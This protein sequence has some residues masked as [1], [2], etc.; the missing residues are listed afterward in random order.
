LT[1]SELS[2]F[3]LF[4]AAFVLLPGLALQRLLRTPIDPA[5][6]VPLG[7]A[8]CAFAF[9]VSLVTGLPALLPAAVVLL[10]AGAW[11]L[12]RGP[13]ERASGPSLRATPTSAS[14]PSPIAATTSPATVTR[15]SRTRCTTARNYSDSWREKRPV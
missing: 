4:A 1:P 9:W 15:A 10:L 11:R 6:A 2:L 3:L 14:S 13:C 7:T 12:G 8:F 5:L